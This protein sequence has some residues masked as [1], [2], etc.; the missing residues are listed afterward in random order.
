MKIYS[1]E[2]LI[3]PNFF[4]NKSFN[5][6]RLAMQSIDK[7]QDN[8]AYNVVDSVVFIKNPTKIIDNGGLKKIYNT[9]LINNSLENIYAKVGKKTDSFLNYS[10]ESDF[11]LEN[12]SEEVEIK[13]GQMIIFETNEPY[14]IDDAC[15]PKD[16]ILAYVSKFDGIK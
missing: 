6:L 12:C 10:D 5:R 3:D 2:M 4:S 13:S 16:I 15:L 7:A 8:V 1:S 11:K 14:Y 9:V